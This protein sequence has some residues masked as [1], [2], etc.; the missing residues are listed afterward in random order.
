MK[1]FMESIKRNKEK[2]LISIIITIGIFVR[3]IGLTQFPQG[4]NQDEASARI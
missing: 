4:L 1:E 2:F 3:V